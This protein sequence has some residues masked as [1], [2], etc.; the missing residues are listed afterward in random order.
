MYFWQ[1]QFEECTAMVFWTSYHWYEAYSELSGSEFD[2]S[3]VFAGHSRENCALEKQFLVPRV[4]RNMYHEGW[5]EPGLWSIW[6]SFVSAIE[7]SGTGKH[8]PLNHPVMSANSFW[9]NNTSFL[10]SFKSHGCLI[11]RV[12]TWVMCRVYTDSVGHDSHV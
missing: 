11:Y 8:S 9:S 12:Q 4:T 5:C 2:G 7:I 1:E 10:N 6:W 3:L